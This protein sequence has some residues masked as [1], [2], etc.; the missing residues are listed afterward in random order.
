METATR[1]SDAYLISPPSCWRY[2]RQLPPWQMVGIGLPTEARGEFRRV[3][4]GGEA[5]IRT[6]ITWSRVPST[7]S[8][9]FRSVWFHAVSCQIT[10]VGSG[11]FRRVLAQ[12]VSSCLTRPCRLS[13]APLRQPLHFQIVLSH[14]RFDLRSPVSSAV[15][16]S[17]ALATANASAYAIA[18]F[19]FN[20]AARRTRRCVASFTG[21]GNRRRN[22]SRQSDSACSRRFTRTRRWNASPRLMIELTQSARPRSASSRQR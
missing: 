18:W 9:P 1:T 15:W 7:G 2:G 8:G 17:I 12:R 13:C 22:A 6:P 14:K 4:V 19:D 16:R 3:K 20:S 21:T 11:P 10:S 5:G